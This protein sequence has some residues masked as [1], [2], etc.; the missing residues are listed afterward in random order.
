MSSLLRAVIVH[1]I[2]LAVVLAVTA[3]II[4]S[5]QVSGVFGVILGAAV[6]GLVNAVIGPVLRLLSLP[7]TAATLGLFSIVVNG[8]LLMIAAGLSDRLS[9]GGPLTTILAALVISVLSV[10]GNLLVRPL[11]R[12][13]EADARAG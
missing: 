4:P 9:V 11:L 1:W 5:V 3:W 6:L 8:V 13:R 12:S 2:V 10:V 7:L